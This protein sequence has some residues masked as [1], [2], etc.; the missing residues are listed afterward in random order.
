[1]SQTAF[2]MYS[3]GTWLGTLSTMMPGE[4]Y[5][6]FSNAGSSKDFKYPMPSASNRQNLAKSIADGDIERLILDCENNMAVVAQVVQDGKVVTDAKVSVYSADELCGYSAADDSKGRHF[7]TVGNNGKTPRLTFMVETSDGSYMLGNLLDYADDAIIGSVRTPF[8]INLNEATSI[9][10]I[11]SGKAIARIE[12][13][14]MTGSLLK[15]ITDPS[16]QQADGFCRNAALKRVIYADGTVSV[17]KV[18][19]KR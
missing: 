10:G 17:I 6:Y 2:A 15:V 4:G 3:D 14:D 9:D 8:V 18:I 5:K 13:Y 11:A 16:Q 19:E 1:M 12:L 7:I